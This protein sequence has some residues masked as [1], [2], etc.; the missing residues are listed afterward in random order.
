[1]VKLIM[2]RLRKAASFALVL[3]L[4][5]ATL[6]LV[7]AVTAGADPQTIGVGD[8][9]M[10]ISGVTNF[11]GKV[12]KAGD[13][14]NDTYDDIV[15]AA[16][17]GYM[18]NPGV[19]Y[20]YSGNPV[21]PA[22]PELL[23]SFTGL[24]RECIDY[25]GTP[26]SGGDRIGADIDYI[27]DVNGD[28]VP[29]LAACAPA[30]CEYRQ[31]THTWEGRFYIIYGRGDR[32][33][34]HWSRIDGVELYT[35]SGYGKSASWA[36]NVDP[37]GPPLDDFL[38]GL[39]NG[40]T[41][42]SF[43]WLIRGV[44]VDLGDYP[45]GG[46]VPWPFATSGERVYSRDYADYNM[47]NAGDVD[48]N[49]G[50]DY[51]I[52][53]TFSPGDVI[54]YAGEDAGLSWMFSSRRGPVSG[55]LNV[56]NDGYDDVLFA[57]YYA[58]STGPIEVWPGKENFFI[59]PH[60]DPLYTNESP[61]IHTWSE[62]IAALGDFNGDG[63]DD[64]AVS[65][66]ANS[67]MNYIGHVWV[68]S[69]HDGSVML[70]IDGD[71]EWAGL[72]FDLSP[73]GDVNADGYDDLLVSAYGGSYQPK[74]AMVF[75]GGPD[76]DGDGILDPYDN[77]PDILN[78]DQADD[79][80]DGVGDVCD[81]C[82]EVA[83]PGQEDSDLDGVG[84][85]CD[86]CPDNWN[87]LQLDLDT[88]GIGDACDTDA[89]VAWGIPHGV[90]GGAILDGGDLWGVG[91][92][93]SNIGSS[94]D[95]GVELIFALADFGAV[96]LG[97]V[98]PSTFPIG[99]F[100]RMAAVDGGGS[101]IG[102]LSLSGGLAGI[103]NYN[104]DLSPVGASSY[105]VKAYNGTM[106][107]DEQGGQTGEPFATCSETIANMAC[108]V[109]YQ[110]GT[111][112]GKPAVIVSFTA[113]HTITIPGSSPVMA[114]EIVV[115]AEGAAAYNPILVPTQALQVTAANI[116]LFYTTNAQI[117]LFGSLAIQGV[118]TS[119]LSGSGA[120]GDLTG[121]E[122]H[123]LVASNL[124]SSGADGIRVWL[125]GPG[126]P[127]ASKAIEYGKDYYMATW[128]DVDTTASLPYDAGI[129]ASTTSPNDL[130]VSCS[131]TK[132][133]SGWELAADFAAMG[134]STYTAN[135]YDDGSLVGT[136]GG[137][138]ATGAIAIQGPTGYSSFYDPVDVKGGL[139]ADTWVQQFMW[140]TPVMVVLTGSGVPLY[141]D[142]LGFVPESPT[143]VYNLATYATILATEIPTVVF[144]DMTVSA[145]CCTVRGDINH[146][147]G[148]SPIDI[149]D[150]VYLVDYMF[151]QGPEPPCLEEADMDA[152]GEFDI[153]D[154]VYLV[155]YMFTG[156]PVP[157]VC[158]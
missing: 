75:L 141:G 114:D 106:L 129:A 102:A 1:M 8:A 46:E 91:L 54:L 38:M 149:A 47:C 82:W 152:S 43:T 77:C 3:T 144:T 56:N 35:H 127:P 134:A 100:I 50:D 36:G 28:G 33:V 103:L 126:F 13:V 10:V 156:G 133:P 12:C 131:A 18:S 151:N 66:P 118:A 96:T 85:L 148:A 19:I 83:N 154:L 71:Y 116:S 16:P 132:T 65:A 64:F 49:G 139:G 81:N 26:R 31:S 40:W 42:G 107:V 76:S 94:G 22:V 143:Q 99:G 145:G 88:D 44:E 95:D 90:L 80:V 158:P 137:L 140:E 21:N 2:K 32:D 74:R 7:L 93:V 92:V 135:L 61:S 79:D 113:P 52:K 63:Y 117:G 86:N 125:A 122:G 4:M 70:V 89:L 138:D 6:L 17:G 84:D 130:T 105:N 150:L 59:Y 30:V 72:G 62:Q 119:V 112:G 39:S 58:S 11:E 157:V 128:M 15:L 111:T 120:Y 14:N 51:L 23:Y 147:G 5:S 124:G 45:G 41:S 73:A 55:P 48:G 25:Y 104:V 78:A 29:D 97:Q 53:N 20:F 101:T 115:I 69:G 108:A 67:A 155:D 87:P 142:V 109:V 34:T 98:D 146:A 153:A 57:S 136:V 27:G 37:T 60:A 110:A 24:T 123:D 68:H 9:Y 121:E